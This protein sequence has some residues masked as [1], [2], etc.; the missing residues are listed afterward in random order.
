MG[1]DY[2]FQT[3]LISY[4]LAFLCLPVHGVADILAPSEMPE[5][6]KYV[7]IH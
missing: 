5:G 1:G 2:Q 4:L 3:L 7:N 6:V